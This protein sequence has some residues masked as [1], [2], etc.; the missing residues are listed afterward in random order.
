M[1]R[2]NGKHYVYAQVSASEVALLKTIAQRDGLSLS[3]F[4]RRCINGYLLELGD[5]DLPMLEER[6]RPG[7]AGRPKTT[8]T[9]RRAEEPEAV[10]EVSSPPQRNPR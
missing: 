4:L 2:S 5:E 3:N 9:I 1:A 7:R 6:T 10:S 8:T